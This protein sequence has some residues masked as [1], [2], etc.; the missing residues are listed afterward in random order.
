MKSVFLK[1]KRKFLVGSYAS[2][3]VDKDYDLIL[4]HLQKPYSM[5]REDEVM[6]NIFRI[7]ALKET[8]QDWSAEFDYLIGRKML[9]VFN[10]DTQAYLNLFFAEKI[11]SKQRPLEKIQINLFNVS[12]TIK[13]HFPIRTKM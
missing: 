5:Q 4:K 2:F 12:D 7:L 6:C 3:Y 1:M 13:K 8:G 9:D 11:F 10:Q